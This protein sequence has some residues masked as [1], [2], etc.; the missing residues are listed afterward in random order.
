MKSKIIPLEISEKILMIGPG[1]YLAYSGGMGYVLNSYYKNFETFNYLKAHEHKYHKAKWPLIKFF[2]GQLLKYI[3][4]LLNNKKIKV[5]HIHGAAYGSFYRKYVLFYIGKFIFSKKVIYHVH[6]SEFSK[7]YTESE[8]F[9]KRLVKHFVENA[10][11]L[12]CLSASWKTFFTTNFKHIKKIEILKNGI[13]KPDIDVDQ[14]I[15]SRINSPQIT[16]LFLGALGNRKGVFDLLN[17]VAIHRINFTGKI[18]IVIGGNGEVERLQ[19]YIKNNQLDDIVHFEGW[20]SGNQK[21]ELLKSSSVYILPTYNEGL[22]IAILEAMSYALPII[23]T[24]VGGIPEIVLNDY[25]GF[26]I[27]PGDIEAIFNSLKRFIDNPELVKN[28]GLLS[29]EI[30]KP[31]YIENVLNDLLL[32]YT[33]LLK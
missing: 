9:T 32:L 7:F 18:K 29:D 4:I 13:E 14:L 11:L 27:T 33:F 16:F 6:G 3:W 24:P 31:Y 21:A 12:I 2:T 25:N 8:N 22:P 23:S 26:L 30:V 19:E 20:V 15:Q 17:T 28:M 10:D 5:L 1:D